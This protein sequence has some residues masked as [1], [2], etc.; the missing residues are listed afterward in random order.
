MIKKVLL[1]NLILCYYSINSQTIS[2]IS[3]GSFQDGLAI[4][5]QG[6]IYGSDFFGPS[7]NVYKYD[8]NGNVTTF[9]SGFVTPNGI[10]INSQDE[11]Y[12]CD[13]F[14]NEI[15]KYD[16]NGTLLANFSNGLFSTPAGIQPIPNTLDML[17]VEYNNITGNTIKRLGS[18]GIVTTLYSGFPL[19]GPAGIT[20]IGE[21]PYIANFN[22]RKI[23]SFLNGTLTEIAQLPSIGIPG[24]GSLGFLTSGNG[25]LYAT[26][27]NDNKIYSIDP[28]SGQV[29]LFAGST[30]G[31]LDGSVSV[32]TFSGPNGIIAD[33]SNGRLYV[34]D[35]STSN[36]RIIDNAFLS[37]NDFALEDF[38]FKIFPNPTKDSLN[39]K[40][41]LNTL[42]PLKIEVIDLLGKIVYKNKVMPKSKDFITSI[43]TTDWKKG[44]YIF[45]IIQGDN[46]LIKK[47][48]I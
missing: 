34:S 21:V 22:D 32:A 26:N 18:D 16:I 25:V 38:D 35:S 4:D 20:F 28:S 19:N 11:I 42:K 10:G 9:A 7:R 5:S 15:R 47:I 12:V 1:F 48:I 30:D 24:G 39:I 2:T 45:K 29:S 17:V 44:T 14:G 33:N 43:P 46:K 31:S 41:S 37:T 8:T 13:H 40:C 23:F 36:L 6:N 27:L 3:E